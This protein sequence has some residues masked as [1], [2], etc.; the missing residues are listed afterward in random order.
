MFNFIA[1]WIEDLKER[2]RRKTIIKQC[3]NICYCSCDEPLNDTATCVEIED[4]L[5]EYT[6]KKCN[7]KSTFAFHIAPVPVIVQREYPPEG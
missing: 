4:G 3:G 5:I 1:D 6:C 2:K 7:V